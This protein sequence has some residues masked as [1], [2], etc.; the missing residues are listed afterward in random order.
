MADISDELIDLERSAE[1]ARAMLA[2]LAGEEYQV[3]CRSWYETDAAVLAQAPGRE[4]RARAAHWALH[5]VPLTVPREAPPSVQLA[6]LI[7]AVHTEASLGRACADDLT[8][9]CATAPGPRTD[10]LDQ[11]ARI[12]TLASWRRDP[13]AGETCWQLPEQT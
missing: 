12:R 13:E 5:P 10:L 1:E 6:A 9:L 2:G 3:Q 11:L 7:L 4:E 8:W